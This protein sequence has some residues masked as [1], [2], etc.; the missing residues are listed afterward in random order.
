MTDEETYEQDINNFCT[1][2][3]RSLRQSTSE[4]EIYKNF[5]EKCKKN[6]I[7]NKNLLDV[8]KKTR[9][10]HKVYGDEV[11]TGSKIET[12]D[13]FELGQEIDT[14]TVTETDNTGWEEKEGEE[15]VKKE[16][17]GFY[18]TITD[19]ATEITKV[20]DELRLEGG[21]SLL[22]KYKTSEDLSSFS[23]ANEP[24]YDS[25]EKT[26]VLADLVE[27]DLFKIVIEDAVV[28]NTYTESIVETINKGIVRNTIPGSEGLENS[29]GR[30]LVQFRSFDRGG[31]EPAEMDETVRNLREINTMGMRPGN[32]KGKQ[33]EDPELFFKMFLKITRGQLKPL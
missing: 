4:T 18:S 1:C 32:Y 29:T 23:S 10:A 3:R 26:D 16:E 8:V 25:P 6:K 22:T 27:S 28:E 13:V 15:A 31:E 17:T 5:C 33:G 12:E 30:S 2:E 19:L 20:T 9:R 14:P 24:V 21:N 11:H 7:Y